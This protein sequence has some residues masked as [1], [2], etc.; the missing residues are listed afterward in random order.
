MPAF[1][2]RR[3]SLQQLMAATQNFSP[4]AIIG[5]G[6]FAKVFRGK[7]DG[8]Q[9]AVKKPRC[10]L[11]AEQ[12]RQFQVELSVLSAIHHPHIIPLIGSCP[13]EALLV[14][15]LADRGSL[16]SHL[17]PPAAP[18]GPD[19]QPQDSGL[20][21]QR[22]L[23]VAHHAALGLHALHSAQPEAILHRD[24]KPSNI[25]LNAHWV[26]MLGDVGLAKIMDMQPGGSSS[27]VMG[28]GSRAAGTVSYWAPEV[29]SNQISAAGD[30]YALGMVMLQMLTGSE[31]AG[32][33]LREVVAQAASQQPGGAQPQ[34]WHQRWAEAPQA[35]AHLA[36]L[37]LKCT[38]SQPRSRPAALALA[39]TLQQMAEAEA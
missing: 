5:E 29:L 31:V 33:L 36:L 10:R 16:Q 39:E 2:G 18:P 22:C 23:Q 7:L 38:D 4:S 37:A 24:I 15:Q 8:L 32:P 27:W 12:A 26:A 14:Y 21:W 11:D 34:A 28:Q 1:Q 20:S 30:I 19:P 25:L 6:S 17:F 3:Y 13:E 9:V 35:A